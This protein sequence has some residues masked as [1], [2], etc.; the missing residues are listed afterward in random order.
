MIY[1]EGEVS[2]QDYGSG[3]S[4]LLLEKLGIPKTGEEIN[5]NTEGGKNKLGLIHGYK[6]VIL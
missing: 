5:E 3:S 4:D 6:R 2:G 1:L